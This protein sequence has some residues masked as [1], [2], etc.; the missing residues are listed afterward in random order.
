MHCW[1]VR[2]GA[3]RTEQSWDLEERARNLLAH[4][5]S[6]SSLLHRE[7][8]PVDISRGLRRDE[9]KQ[10]RGLNGYRS[11]KQR[12]TKEKVKV[13]LTRQFRPG[14]VLST[15]ITQNEAEQ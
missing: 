12:H 7:P 14:N 3:R 9:R 10:S 13:L 1:K 15:A 5:E 6:Q 11:E 8:V 4:T 2:A